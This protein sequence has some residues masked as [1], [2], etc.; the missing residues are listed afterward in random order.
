[1]VN[2][3]DLRVP[4]QIAAE[5]L[6]KTGRVPFWREVLPNTFFVLKIKN[7]FKVLK[8]LTYRENEIARQ[9][10][11]IEL[12]NLPVEKAIIFSFCSPEH[13]PFASM[14]LSGLNFDGSGNISGSVSTESIMKNI[15]EPFANR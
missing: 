15:T 8:V 7:H 4:L 3:S 1:M 12:H 14:N 6:S 9:W 10:I 13:L 2:I 5:L 11:Q